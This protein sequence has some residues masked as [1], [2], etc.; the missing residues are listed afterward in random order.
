MHVFITSTS[1]CVFLIYNNIND[2]GFRI[3]R[4]Y[5][6]LLANDVT[7]IQKSDRSSFYFTQPIGVCIAPYSKY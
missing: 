4:V 3:W 5:A 1:T 2:T 7:V 6:G